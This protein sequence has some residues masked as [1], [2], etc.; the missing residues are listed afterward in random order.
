[1]STPTTNRCLYCGTPEQVL[2]EMAGDV[3]IGFVR[4]YQCDCDQDARRA[5]LETASEV[6]MEY[7]GGSGII[8][9]DEA[10][11]DGRAPDLDLPPVV[12]GDYIILHRN[13]PTRDE[14]EE[15]I[16]PR[17][18]DE[19]DM[20]NAHRAIESVGGVPGLVTVTDFSKQEGA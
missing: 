8:D 14:D 18:L 1:M 11:R 2:H 10:V 3:Y 16:E 4:E 15:W 13:P 6:R 5:E 9:V 7:A 20:I 17:V 19:G 12:A